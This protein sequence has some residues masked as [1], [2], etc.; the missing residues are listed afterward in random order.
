MSET[1]LIQRIDL[2]SMLDTNE[3]FPVNMAFSKDGETLIVNAL[4]IGILLLRVSDGEL[5]EMIEGQYFLL[6]Y[7]P[8]SY[9]AALS[10]QMNNKYIEVWD[11]QNDYRSQIIEFPY[12]C[13]RIALIENTVACATGTTVFVKEI[14]ST[15]LQ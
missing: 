5:I 14:P 7:S 10:F 3:F 4:N 6:Q 15:W 13:E 11:V 2:L 1:E 9:L 8:D 12:T